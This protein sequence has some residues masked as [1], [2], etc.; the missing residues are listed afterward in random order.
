MPDYS[1]QREKLNQAVQIL[2]EQ[3]LDLWMTF[4]RETSHNADP[5]L[6]LILGFDV[7]WPS[8]FI[9]TRTGQKIAIVGAYDV[10]NVERMGGYDEVIG[11]HHFIQPSLME[12]LKRFNPMFIAVNYSESDSS[13]DGLS[14]GM[15]LHLASYFKYTSYRLVSAETILRSLR[16]QKS[17]SEIAHIR[18]A[19]GITEKIIDSITAYLRPGL[20]EVE[21]AQFVHQEF[22]RHGVLPAWER[23]YCPIVNCG[24]DSI[25]GHSAPSAKNIAQAGHL[26]H[27]DLGIKHNNYVSDLQRVWYLQPQTETEIPA[28]IQ[29]GFDAVVGAIQAAAAVLK[30]HVQ[31]LTVDKIARDFIIQAGYPE[32]QHAL[33]HQ[34][35][36]TVHDGGTLLGP[37]WAK[38]GASVTSQVEVGNIFTLELEVFVEG[39]GGIGLEEDVLVTENGLEWLATPQTAPIIIKV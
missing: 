31:G 1:I 25:M 21:I 15:Y 10:E 11:Y 14:H 33:G 36:R 19:V 8:A 34:I 18:E 23:E 5:A 12:V 16:G 39:H 13:A 6:S 38:Y 28:A 37:Q 22:E 24:P 27:I 17:A 3:D 2:Q 9:V 26:I 35:G 4:V 30:P 32:F 20:N 29:A 7:T